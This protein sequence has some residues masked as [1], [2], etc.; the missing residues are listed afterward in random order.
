MERVKL[1]R[2]VRAAVAGEWDA[3]DRA[4]DSHVT[5]V[6]IFYRGGSDIVCDMAW[7]LSLRLKWSQTAIRV[8][9]IPLWRRLGG[10]GGSDN[11]M[12]RSAVRRFEMAAIG[13]IGL[14]QRGGRCEAF[15][16]F[17]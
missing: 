12:Q 5:T 2:R 4:N 9:I 13:R 10:R 14:R 3:D 1:P 8:S 11:R 6:A 7:H 16:A 15:G 17:R